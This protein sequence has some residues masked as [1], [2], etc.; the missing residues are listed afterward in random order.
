MAKYYSVKCSY[1]VN[2]QFYDRAQSA[3]AHNTQATFVTDAKAAYA[4]AQGTTADQIST[5][6]IQ[7]NLSTPKTNSLT[8]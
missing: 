3:H 8:I 2:S 7:S 4:V 5:T 6:Q 1:G